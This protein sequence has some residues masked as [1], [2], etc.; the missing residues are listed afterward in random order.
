MFG[1]SEQT[2]VFLRPGI[3]DGWMGADGLTGLVSQVLGL[4][5]LAGDLFVFCNRRRNR[6]CACSDMEQPVRR[7]AAAIARMMRIQIPAVD[8]PPAKF[9]VNA[10]LASSC[11]RPPLLRLQRERLRRIGFGPARLDSHTDANSVA[12]QSTRPRRAPPEQQD[13]LHAS[14]AAPGR[15]S[16]PAPTPLVLRS[17]CISGTPRASIAQ[18]FAQRAPQD[19]RPLQRPPPPSAAGGPPA[20]IRGELRRT[21]PPQPAAPD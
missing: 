20:P 7:P 1:L 9:S 6:I 11:S 14:A 21:P 5:V 13:L 2:R 8:D 3:T 16:A 4:D 18:L 17:R 10:A 19:R 15:R 12:P